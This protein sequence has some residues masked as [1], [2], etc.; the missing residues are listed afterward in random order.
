M[1]S[2]INATTSCKI[3]SFTLHIQLLAFKM[4]HPTS[5]EHLT[6]DHSQLKAAT[7]VN[8]RF[9]PNPFVSNFKH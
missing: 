4:W 8:F 5:M 2:V 7:T 6:N 9:N 3:E 1:K